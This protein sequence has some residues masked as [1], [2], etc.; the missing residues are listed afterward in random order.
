MKSYEPMGLH[1]LGLESVT[2]ICAGFIPFHYISAFMLQTGPA[3]Q[4][5]HKMEI[6]CCCESDP[7]QMQTSLANIA[8]A[9]GATLSWNLKMAV[10]PTGD[11]PLSRLQNVCQSEDL[12]LCSW[13]SSQ[14]SDGMFND[15]FPAGV[16]PKIPEFE[17][18]VLTV[19]VGLWTHSEHVSLFIDESWSNA[20]QLRRK[21]K[22]KS[23]QVPSGF[24]AHFGRAC[25]IS[26]SDHFSDAQ[27]AGL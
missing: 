27:K 4:P 23:P 5:R 1:H 10:Q 20:E 22:W 7:H 15:D 21:S 24:S 11:E 16:W 8:K 18:A 17:I 9:K 6:S 26:N 3:F 12:P 19:Q 25:A 2:W 13:S 14:Q